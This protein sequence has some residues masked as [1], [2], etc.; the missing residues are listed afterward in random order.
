MNRIDEELRCLKRIEITADKIF[1]NCKSRINENMR[2]Y[3]NQKQISLLF[4]L[5][6]I[7]GSSAPSIKTDAH[8]AKNLQSQTFMRRKK[9]SHWFRTAATTFVPSKWHMKSPSMFFISKNVLSQ[10]RPPFMN[11]DM[12]HCLCGL[13]DGYFTFPRKAMKRKCQK[14]EDDRILCGTITAESHVNNSIQIER[15]LSPEDEAPQKESH[16]Q[17]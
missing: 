17:R 9:S 14:A 3:V 13:A 5:V 8:S 15:I 11:R 7:K 16:L 1:G 12:L 6:R 4:S 10:T 2:R